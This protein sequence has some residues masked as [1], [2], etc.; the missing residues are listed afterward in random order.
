MEISSKNAKTK[1][2]LSYSR[3]DRAEAD[4]IIAALEGAGIEFLRDVDDTLPSEQWWQ[5]ITELIQMSDSVIFVL[6]SRSAESSVCADE[7][8]LAN[9]LSKR[10]FPVAIETVRWD[11]IP[12]GLAK[13]HSVFLHED[14]DANIMALADAL[15]T[16]ID[17]VRE[18]TRLQLRALAWS[19][20]RPKAELLR[21]KSLEMAEAWRRKRPTGA[22]DIGRLLSDY[23]AASHEDTK[24]RTRRWLIG[25]G[26]AVVSSTTLAG[27]AVLQRNTAVA[28]R[29]RALANL[30]VS[31]AYDSL[32]SDPTQAL[33]HALDAWHRTP[34]SFDAHIA[35]LRAYYE[36]PGFPIRL[37]RR[38]GADWGT[39]DPWFSGAFLPGGS[40]IL[41]RDL[42]RPSTVLLVDLD[43]K[44][45]MLETSS[46]I[47]RT[48]EG[49][50]L[51]GDYRGVEVFKNDLPFLS[52]SAEFH[53][54][55]YSGAFSRAGGF[56]E[57]SLW[58]RPIHYPF[59][60]EVIEHLVFSSGHF[61]RVQ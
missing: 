10:V 49:F 48:A 26:A 6:S 31:K 28:E 40:R 60:P 36:A 50:S 32:V 9:S 34:R 53:D 14:F 5:R 17:W 39:S 2:F 7:I 52:L 45:T 1:V 18:K 61:G 35:V 37:L 22:E 20:E 27:F 57:V 30:S 19:K 55:V 42:T 24:L 4:R 3:S 51:K 8:A 23:L 15:L 21:G 47:G 16:D 13:I 43:G 58:G 46:D 44:T 12:Q 25:S 41:S 33:R 11:N 38:S 59:H 29:D 54:S 56:V